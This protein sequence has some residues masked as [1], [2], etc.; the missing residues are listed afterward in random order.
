MTL[1]IIKLIYVSQ[2]DTKYQHVGNQKLA[3]WLK[4]NNWNKF[5]LNSKWSTAIDR[6]VIYIIC[7]FHNYPQ[8]N[9]I[10]VP[11]LV[12]NMYSLCSKVGIWPFAFFAFNLQTHTRTRSLNKVNKLCL[13]PDGIGGLFFLVCHSWDPNKQTN[14]HKYQPN[15][16]SFSFLRKERQQTHRHHFVF[17]FCECFFH[18]RPEKK[19]S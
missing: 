16:A 15:N 19:H 14:W 9:S 2:V 12:C 8:W 4:S 5:Q 17:I 3:F 1:I 7:L 13:N 18:F 10:S 11:C 6:F